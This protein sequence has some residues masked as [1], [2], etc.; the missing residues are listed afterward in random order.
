LSFQQVAT[1][2]HSGYPVA[3]E[4]KIDLLFLFMTSETPTNYK[5]E[6]YSN[7]QREGL[8]FFFED[9]EFFVRVATKGEKAGVHDQL[10]PD[11]ID[12]LMPELIA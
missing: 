11:L 7:F 9:D 1:I 8:N 5:D 12:Q 6:M 10:K 4:V 2:I 3:L